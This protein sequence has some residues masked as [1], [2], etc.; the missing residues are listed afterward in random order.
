[1]ICCVCN[2]EFNPLGRQKFCA[3]KCRQKHF[4]LRFKAQHGIPYR[5]APR[6]IRKPKQFG[7]QKSDR[8]VTIR[9]RLTTKPI[10]VIIRK[11]SYIR[12]CIYS[13][14][15]RI[16]QKVFSI[17]KYGEQAARLAASLLR[18]SWIIE[19]KRWSPSDGDPLE[20]MRYADSFGEHESSTNE[21][22]S[23]WTPER[24]D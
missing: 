9:T 4:S 12:V 3:G 22:S 2:R 18:L 7:K 17:S 24:E 6:S 1:M 20:I 16:K 23:P 14:G 13:R 11:K 19:T 10:K 8:K 15:I 21:E 5:S